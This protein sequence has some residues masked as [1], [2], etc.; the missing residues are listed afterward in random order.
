MSYVYL[1]GDIVEEQVAGV[2]LND[3]GLMRG[4]GVF[5]VIRTF[6]K[7]PF[8]FDEH[9]A[10]LTKSATFMGLQVPTDEAEIKEATGI[11]I[12]KNKIESEAQIRIMLTGGPTADGM[13]FNIETPT[14]CILVSELPKLPSEYFEKG[15]T[16]ITVEHERQTPQVKTLDYAKAVRL[17]GEVKK[18]G[19]FELLYIAG[20]NVL[21]ATTS[22]FFIVKNG[23]V[24]TPKDDI[25][26]GTTRNYVIDLAHKAGM[27]LE[28]R[29]VTLEEALSADEAFITAT[30]KDIVPVT[31]VDDHAIG[32]GSPGPITKKLMELF[33][34]SI[35][36]H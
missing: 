22:N 11:L 1:N 4:Y 23:V 32:T 6:N 33:S 2:P 29:R 14:F 17:M 18:K 13:T 15:I 36:K 28:E 35:K 24:A 34:N 5:E 25:L 31:R 27:P 3:I 16:L 30:N 12:D 26:L 10:R 19:G 8:L 20:G 9:L 21:E 7:R